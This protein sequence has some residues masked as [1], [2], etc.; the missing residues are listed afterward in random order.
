MNDR[1]RG[2]GRVL[3]ACGLLATGA[4][5]QAQ[6]GW[7]TQAPLPFPRHSVTC[8]SVNGLMYAFGGSNGSTDTATVEVYDPATNAWVSKTPMPGG[9][10]GCGAAEINGR[11]YV[12]GGWTTSP[13]LPNSS[14]W[15]YD[16]QSGSGGSWSSLPGL[17]LHLSASGAAGA[18]DGKLYITTPEN[19][20]SGFTQFLDIYDPVAHA[21]TSGPNSLE[22]HAVPGF[23]VIR[24][25]F[26]VAGGVNAAGQFGNTVEVYDPVS[27]TWAP[28]APMPDHRAPA[29]S[30][31]VNGKLYLAGGENGTGTDLASVLVYDPVAD[32]WSTNYPPMPSGRHACGGACVNGI[33]YVVGGYRAGTALSDTLALGLPCYANCDGSTTSPVLN[34]L[35]FACFINK[36]AA[37]CT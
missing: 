4:Q 29:A 33:F 19:G 16:P 12:V 7:S 1:N 3:V 6:V 24:G 32:S 28:C 9:R 14:L 25:K 23:G 10:Y 18:I 11:V 37:G 8:A 13:P 34:V 17:P 2:V 15:V 31:V 21:W 20:F 30:A 22:A 35:D 36:F 5:V 26:Y 27:N